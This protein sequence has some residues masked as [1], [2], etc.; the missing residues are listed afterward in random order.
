MWSILRE[1]NF[2][3]IPCQHFFLVVFWGESIFF[4]FWGKQIQTQ[5]VENHCLRSYARGR[6]TFPV[7]MFCHTKPESE[8]V[9]MKSS[10]FS[11]HFL[12]KMK[13]PLKKTST[14]NFLHE[15]AVI[16]EWNL[17]NGITMS[18]PHKSEWTWKKELHEMWFSTCKTS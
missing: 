1:N 18:A 14:E 7:E 6:N 12:Q 17:C 5:G 10:L 15:H 4:N 9:E 16:Y 3:S 2:P 11:F 13:L 8:T